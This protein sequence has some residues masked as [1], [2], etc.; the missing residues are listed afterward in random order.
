MLRVPGQTPQYAVV[1]STPTTPPPVPGVTVSYMVRTTARGSAWSTEQPITYSGAVETNDP[2]AAPALR[3]SGQTLTWSAVAKVNT[4]ILVSKVPGKPDRYSVVDGTSTTPPA[5]P[6]KT[7]KYSV[8]T[9]VDG[10]AWAPDVAITYPALTT[11]VAPPT[12]PVSTPPTSGGPGPMWV[13]LNAGGWGPGIVGDVA[14]AVNTIRTP[15][16]E[17]LAPWTKAGVKVIALKSGP[18]N[19]G[20]VQAI[21]ASKWAE[22]AVAYVRANPEIAAYEVLNEPGNKWIGW[23]S[24]AGDQANATAYAHLLKVVHEAF[25]ANGIRTRILASYDGGEGPTTWGEEVFK[26]DPNVGSYID[27]LTLHSYGGTSS[28]SA[29]ALGS[30]YHIEAAH[31]QHPGIPIYVTE[32]GWSTEVEEQNVSFAW[33]QEQQAANIKSFIEWAKGTGYVADV[34]IFGYR[35]YGTN[36]WF[37][38]EKSN[39]THKLSYATLVAFRH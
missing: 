17:P 23:G 18:Y 7:V 34:T 2:Q 37:G 32:V 12:P 28:R 16:S 13:S 22:E 20:G 9:A 35:D 24:S 6:G 31:A 15:V 10:S 8:R 1:R 14:G 5:V 30:R 38:I 27:G 11:P 33:T 25:V 3:V 29:S 19:S 21:D 36:S 26:A 39:R 4:Y